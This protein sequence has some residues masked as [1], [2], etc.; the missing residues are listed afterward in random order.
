[1][2]PTQSI[3]ATMP[4]VQANVV[5]R[6]VNQRVPLYA[7]LAVLA[8]CAFWILLGSI[9][10][11]GARLHDFLNLYTGASLARDGAFAG[12][13]APEV[14]LQRE[15][16]YAPQL[17]EL[18]PFVRPP[19]YALFLAPLAWL[20]FGA[21]FWAWLGVQISVLAGTWL[22][23]FRRWGADALIL[24]SMYLPTALGIAH[25]QDCVLIL[26][27]VLGVY[28]LAQRGQNFLSG[29]VLGTGL[30][31]FHLFLLWP[32]MLLIQRR[33]RML[34]GA[35]A[36][37]TA[38]VLISLLLAGPRGIA[39]YVALLRMS[40]LRHLNPSPELMVNAR[41]IALNLGV[42]NIAVTGFLTLAAVILTAAACWR[43]P[44]WRA[45]AAA[46]AGSLL[47]APHVYGYD[48][49]LLLVGLWLAVFESGTQS[50]SQA[51]RI[52]AT[53]LLTP[54]PML[55]SLAG[56]PWAAATSLALFAF[57]ASLAWMSRSVSL[58]KIQEAI[59]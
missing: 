44:L 2:I 30:I 13:H 15:R 55:L 11:Q 26:W 47:V 48:A 52:A 6:G 49:G 31:K 35:C 53:I 22:W 3:P 1:V 20:P 34:A 23:A 41:S 10:V 19:F 59:A 50:G 24:G 54:I 33:W 21:A 18:V 14:Q 17:P 4:V 42:D 27:I 8:F 56:S 46:S 57:L 43:A 58:E 51:P 45:I 38:E 9:V 39:K 16:E 7:V 37:V 12:M 29:V 25:G 5:N 36:A 40:D 28:A 32:V